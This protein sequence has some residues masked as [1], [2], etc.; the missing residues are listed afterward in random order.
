MRS[1]F[2]NCKMRGTSRRIILTMLLLL[3][4]VLSG[5]SVYMGLHVDLS[6]AV[7]VY[8]EEHGRGAATAELLRH[9]IERRTGISLEV[10]TSMPSDGSVAIA[11]GT[12][13]AFPASYKLPAKLSVPAKA[14]GYAIWFDPYGGSESVYLVGR[15]DK[16]A[17]F[18]VGR[19]IRLLSLS[20]NHIHLKAGIRITAAPDCAIRA[21][22]IIRSTQCEDGFVDWRDNAAERQY[23]RDLILFGTNGFEARP[24]EHID[25][26]LEE[27]DIDL[28]TIVT[29][30]KAIDHYEL[31]DD[32][33]RKLYT[34]L[35]GVDHFTTYGGDA[36]GSSPPMGVFPKLDRVAPLILESHPGAKWWYSNQCLKAHA[37][38]YDEYIFNYFQTKQPS[39]LY[40]MVY[41][42][43]T[44]RG[45]REIRADLPSQYVI[46]H[47]S[48]ICHVRWGQYP[49][50]EWDLAWAQI[51]PRN[52]SIYAMPAMAAQV[53]KATRGDTVGFLPYNHTGSYN[54]LN[55][56]VWSAMGWGGAGIEDVLYDYGRAFFACEFRAHPDGVI[57]SGSRDAIIDAGSRAVAQGLM[58]LGANWKGRLA[59]NTSAEAAEK[60]WKKIAKNMG[61]VGKNWRLEMFLY[62]AVL[63]AQAKRKYDAERKYEDQAY[64]ALKQAKMVGVGK[65]VKDARGAL[66]KID[67]DFQSKAAF[68]K[69][70]KSLGLTGKFGD[71][72]EVVGNIY[73]PL[74]DRKWLEKQLDGVSSLAD[75]KRIVDYEDAGPGG[76]YD[77]LGAAGEQPHLVRQKSWEEDPGFVYSP[78]NWVDHKPGSDRRHSQ[79][80]HAVCR[81]ETPLL[82]RWEGL[83]SAAT[84]RMK[85]VHRGPF[86]PQFTCKT[87][88]GHLVHGVRGK[89]EAEPVEYSI[90][91]AA[92]RDGVLELKWELKNQVRGVS[93]TEIWL[94]KN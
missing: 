82:M 52:H 44:K 47:Y 88:D 14:E 56:F 64:E 54:D 63:D 91:K 34:D 1:A 45:I 83:D 85:V 27:L 30:Q 25:D 65:A 68:M 51:W 76:F 81:Y 42:P 90:P 16:G 49:V 67:T 31:S 33:I 61:G 58:L 17:V 20:A 29:C 78:V 69:E 35:V 55:K 3:L 93:V 92:T 60:L 72:E 19:L 70:L 36:S 86:G 12:F 26:F 18:A 22:Q 50:P 38:D 89:T 24:P 9:E 8:S 32:Q 73:L 43:W 40:G 23:A 48:E 71:L 4:G 94:I 84:Y 77:N 46:R 80:T 15:D 79:M 2:L 21:H 5:G 37:V 13:G 57:K 59:D 7:I 74:N 11:I 10:R 6:K 53:H 87:D 75:I 39:W 62:K 41:G 28:F 66:A